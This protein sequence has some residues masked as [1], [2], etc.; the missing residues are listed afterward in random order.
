MT[1]T[2]L[3]TPIGTLLG[4]RKRNIA[5]AMRL[6]AFLLV[7]PLPMFSDLPLT[8]LWWGIAIC[9]AS[10]LPG[11][12]WSLG[13]A[14]GIPIFPIFAITH[15]WAFGLP[16]LTAHPIIMNYPA[17]NVQM[18]AGTVVGFL[19]I[20][21]IV[22][23][24]VAKNPSQ[25]SSMR[26][27]DSRAGSGL[28]WLPLIAS[29]AYNLLTLADRADIL[30]QFNSIIRASI[31]G[32]N[33]LA[34]FILCIRWGN[35]QLTE[36]ARPILAFMILLQLA[37][38]AA[39]LLLIGA[40]TTFLIAL[41]AYTA[42]KGRVPYLAAIAVILTFTFLHV[43]KSE[44]R[45]RYWHNDSTVVLEPQEIP[46]WYGEW[47]AA[48]LDASTADMGDQLIGRQKEEAQPL[49]WRSSTMQLLLMAQDLTPSQLP[50]MDG[51]TYE[52]IPQLI[53]P[54]ILNPNKLRTHEGTHRLNVHYGMQ[55]Y[56]DTFTTTIGWGLLNEAFANFGLKGVAGLA[57]IIGA[58]YGWVTRFSAPGSLLSLRVLSAVLVM[59]YAF[60]TEFSAGVYISA[61]FQSIIALV[62]LSFVIMRSEWMPGAHGHADEEA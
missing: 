56:E 42:G 13:K 50:F 41:V 28:V 15:L 43:G 11:Y 61:L 23:L 6:G 2:L 47:I 58:L 30:G 60:Q 59:S 37:T 9:L 1:T 31:L 16:L 51:E 52:I 25:P 19:L 20:A 57:V 39:G 12:L 26:V 33:T 4:G 8:H 34:V 44:M 7:V 3:E 35:G 55:R 21:T 29:I 27:I 5:N 36:R 38:D 10:M 32:L 18:A 24:R 49:W 17:E 45:E 62:A 22:W 46:G 48:S 40:M 53:I 14:P 54:R